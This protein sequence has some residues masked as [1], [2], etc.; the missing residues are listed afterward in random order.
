MPRS[1]AATSRRR[2]SGSSRLPSVINEQGKV[3]SAGASGA[4]KVGQVTPAPE[5][6]FSAVAVI[7]DAI[8]GRLH[9][10]D[11]LSVNSHKLEFDLRFKAPIALDTRNSPVSSRTGKLLPPGGGEPGRAY[12][13]EQKAEIA[14]VENKLRS[15]SYSRDE[16][17]MRVTRIKGH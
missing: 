11:P 6:S 15:S 16:A 14:A 2:G 3:T 1:G 5:V 17:E 8:E 12:V 7:D 13:E 9:S 4:G 10:N